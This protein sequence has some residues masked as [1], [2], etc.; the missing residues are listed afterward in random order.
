[1]GILP[2]KAVIHETAHR[3]SET[4]RRTRS[5][6]SRRIGTAVGPGGIS[7]IIAKVVLVTGDTIADTDLCIGDLIAEAFHKGFVGKT[8][9][10]ADTPE[11]TPTIL[12]IT[13]LGGT[14]TTKG[15]GEEVLVVVD[16]VA[17][18]KI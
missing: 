2:G 14:V 6:G 1:M 11:I 17:T 4:V 12:F 10:T 16:I 5:I 9:A 13:E 7:G 3:E 18:D 8:P 15:S